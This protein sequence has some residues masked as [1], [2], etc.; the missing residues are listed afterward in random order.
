MLAFIHSRIPQSGISLK[1]ARKNGED[2]GT[3]L[4]N[5]QEEHS[6]ERRALVASTAQTTGVAFAV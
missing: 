3:E 6:R 1:A 5:A 2:I 4:K